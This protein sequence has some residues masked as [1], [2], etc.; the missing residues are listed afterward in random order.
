MTGDIAALSWRASFVL[1]ALP[2]FAL[3]WVVL[4][5]PGTH[6]GGRSPLIAEGAEPLAATPPAGAEDDTTPTPTDAQLIASS[7]GVQ[8]DPDKILDWDRLGSKSFNLIEAARAG[9]E[10]PHQRHSDRGQRL[11]VLLPV[12]DRDLRGRVREGAVQHRPAP[13]QSPAPRGRG[14]R[15]PRGARLRQLEPTAC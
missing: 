14:R 6:R 2:A 9:A 1:L 11:R 8:P 7:R 15:H 12:R 3:G 13:G 5:C 4:P 10:H